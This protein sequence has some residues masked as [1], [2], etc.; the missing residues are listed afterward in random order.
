MIK[1]VI[2][3]LFISINTQGQLSDFNNIDFKEADE[4]A[5]SYKGE[6]LKSMPKL[7]YN[8]THSL[9]T[10]IEKFRAIYIWVCTNIEND[11][12]NFLKNA[13]SRD[14][15]KNDSLKLEEWNKKFST[16]VFKKLLKEQKTICTGYAYLIKELS[17][18]AEIK[19]EIV[20]GYGRTINL[21][22][23]EPYI[24]NHSWNAVQL[25]SKWYLC[26]ATW[27]S[28]F[29]N[30]DEYNFEYNYT[31]GYFLTDPELFVK[32]H[33]PL[34]TSWLLTKKEYKLV[35]FFKTPFVYREAFKYGIMPIEPLYMNINIIENEEIS[36]LL[37]EQLPIDENN[38]SIELISG[39]GRYVSSVKP[40]INRTKEGFLELKYTFK[41]R[42]FY[43]VHIKINDA[44]LVTYIVKVKREK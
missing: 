41:D 32:N 8:L 15:F 18:L 9:S 27:S 25:N 2:L 19:C 31:D 7:A 10:D 34:D 38:I 12:T 37:K 23:K 40:T 35:D 3:F 42:G 44:Y 33:Y 36:F 24:P 17:N 6:N 14:K 26:D 5:Y 16:K 4:I 20:D 39:N 1:K 30:I 28:G 43:D 11:Y 13:K 22:N 21:N 29:F